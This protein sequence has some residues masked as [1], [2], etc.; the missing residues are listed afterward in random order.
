MS[1]FTDK[2]RSAALRKTEG[3]VYYL[4]IIAY[5]R[6]EFGS[7]TQTPFFVSQV[8]GK[9][10]FVD[11]AKLLDD[12]REDLSVLA[13]EP[14]GQT[15]VD[16]SLETPYRDIKSE[17]QALEE[18]VAAP[19]RISACANA[20]FDNVIQK[21]SSD[22]FSDLFEIHTIE[23]DTLAEES[24]TA[25]IIDV[26]LK[27][28]RSD[29]FVT[30][31]KRGENDEWREVTNDQGQMSGLALFIGAL[32]GTTRSSDERERMYR[33]NYDVRL[34]CQMARAQ[35]KVTLTPR[36][37]S[38]RQLVIVVTCVPSIEQCYVFGVIYE[39]RLLDFDSFDY[40]GDEIARHCWRLSWGGKTNVAVA[41]I[42][43]KLRATIRSNLDDTRKRLP[44]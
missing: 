23:H 2:F 29:K 7:T 21:C 37:R 20:F 28:R 18:S 38:L 6:D 11:D 14:N 42:A 13:A 39:H 4:D 25:H 10:T 12:L 36:Y 19:E 30:V 40:K 27:E 32:S 16:A 44:Q 5:L 22:E 33:A 15:N 35:L 8:T 43:E 24:A 26:L 41:A 1:V 31:H 17:L 3:T 34:N 9:E